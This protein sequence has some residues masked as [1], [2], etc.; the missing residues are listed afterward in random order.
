VCPR[1]ATNKYFN[2]TIL[3]AKIIK[4]ALQAHQQLRALQLQKSA[5]KR[6][7]RSYLVKLW[8][9]KKQLWTMAFE[10]ELWDMGYEKSQK[11]F[12]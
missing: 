2:Y 7:I 10:K 6:E 12:G 8:L 11:L 5:N 4:Q 1:S 9:L 3:V